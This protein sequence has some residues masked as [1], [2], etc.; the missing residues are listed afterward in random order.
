MIAVL[1]EDEFLQLHEVHDV[2]LRPHGAQGMAQISDES[3][4]WKA[5]TDVEAGMQSLQEDLVSDVRS[6]RFNLKP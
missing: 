5:W 6:R 4:R 1:A 2:K 3:V